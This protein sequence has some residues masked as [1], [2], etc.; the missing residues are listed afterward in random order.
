MKMRVGSKCIAG[1]MLCLLLAGGCG[2]R[3]DGPPVVSAEGT[4]TLD[5]KP[6]ANADI[7][8]EPTGSTPGQAVF[9]KT[10]SAG[11]FALGT[12]DGKRK[13]A[14]VGSY[15]VVINKLVKPDGTDFIPDPNQG[16]MDTGGFKEL[17]Q[18]TYSVREQSQL[19]AEIPAAG[20]KAL[21]FT[22][23]SKGK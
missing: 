3:S 21:Q 8:L 6:L 11:K 10:D 18:P 12:P 14:A 2:S 5:G 1:G 23:K 22:L 13:G 9:A 15:I 19:T 20:N 7:M 16:P 17:L 4:V